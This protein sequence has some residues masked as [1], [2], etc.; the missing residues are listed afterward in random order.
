MGH[1]ILGKDVQF[2]P[3]QR[4]QRHQPYRNSHQH[5][6]CHRAI[7]IFFIKPTDFMPVPKL[8]KNKINLKRRLGKA[9]LVTSLEQ[10][11]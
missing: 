2:N 7:T 1:L 3:R 10:S 4:Y 8:K 6:L 9:M 11:N 5:Q